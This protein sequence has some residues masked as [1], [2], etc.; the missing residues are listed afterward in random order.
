MSRRKSAKNVPISPWLSAREDCREGRFIQVGDTLLVSKRFQALKPN[1]K[2]LYFALAM[3][4]GGKAK[5]KLSHGAAERKYGISSTTYDRAI[6]DLIDGGFIRQE[7]DEYRSQ[8][9]TNE[10]TFVNDWKKR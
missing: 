4:S 5:V 9:R 3:D 2:M 8:F 1:S 6:K 10:F 7:L